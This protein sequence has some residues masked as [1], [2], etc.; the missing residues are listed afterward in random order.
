MRPR[1]LFHE[2]M[3]VRPTQA[4]GRPV[5]GDGFGPLPGERGHNTEKISFT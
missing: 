2:A 4:E 5:G 1:D 3:Q